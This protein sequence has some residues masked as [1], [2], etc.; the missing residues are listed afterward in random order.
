MMSFSKVLL[1][2]ANGPANAN[3]RE[4]IVSFSVAAI[5]AKDAERWVILFSGPILLKIEMSASTFGIFIPV[6]T[7]SFGN[8]LKFN[9][10]SVIVSVE[11]TDTGEVRTATVDYS[12][13]KSEA[14]ATA[15]AIEEASNKF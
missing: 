13:S 10:G 3:L 4:L 2:N 6:K 1:R 15:E 14:E 8:S 5:N 12:P 11:D 7:E 9:N